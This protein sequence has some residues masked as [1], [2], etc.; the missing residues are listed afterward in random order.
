MAKKNYNLQ[1]IDTIY[2]QVPAFTDL[3]DED[4]WYVFAGCFVAGTC[5]LV[6][7]LSRFITIQPVD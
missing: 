3:F 4:T 7:L 2:E 6:F 1:L 5:V